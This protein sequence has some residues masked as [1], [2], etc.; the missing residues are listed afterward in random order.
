MSSSGSFFAVVAR[1]GLF[2]VV[3]AVELL[4]GGL[5]VDLFRADADSRWGSLG[6]ERCFSFLARDGSRVVVRDG[7]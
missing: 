4:E 6:R 3:L 7:S 1:G 5:I 2:I